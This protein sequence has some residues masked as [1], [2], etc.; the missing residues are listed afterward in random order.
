[1]FWIVSLLLMLL[2]VLF[3]VV[4]V[5][6]FARLQ[7]GSGAG[8]QHHRDSANLM[9]FEER[10][11]EL[12]AEL[13][14]GVLDEEQHQALKAELQRTL[15]ADIKTEAA[16][17]SHSSKEKQVAGKLAPASLL[18]PSRLIPMLT[19]VLMLPLSFYLYGLWGF[20]S[21]LQIAD[22]FERSRDNQGDPEEL[23]DLIFE[24]GA[25]IEADSE[26]GWAWYYLA[27]HLVSLGQINEAARAFERAAAFVE[28]S[29]DRAII[30]GQYAQAAYIAAGQQITADVQEIID[31]AQRLDPAEQSVLQ[32]LGADAFINEN[33]QSAMT[34]WQQ[35][36]GISQRADDREFLQEMIAEAQQR[37]A[38]AGDVSVPVDAGPRLQISLSLDPEL[39]LPPQT[40]V[41]VSAQDLQQA[42]PPLAAKVLT[43]ADLPTVVT[44]SDAD[45]VG[46][47][48]LSSATEVVIVATVSLG[49]SADVQSG[50]LQARSPTLPLSDDEP[51][52]LQLLIADPLP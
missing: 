37:M 1:M 23:R 38:A 8:G 2:A 47:V 50:D 10:L 20:E 12:D 9:I 3:V 30:L 41:F 7:Q 49:G 36:L 26:N 31:Q 14:A 4:P 11:A 45:A 44:L 15:L 43:V 19:I 5:L 52:R 16:A 21:D 35:L 39:D 13:D 6:R 24:L 29:Q 46:P 27:R 32:L 33:Y 17:E 22:V 51:V 40:R 48:N 25:I 18:I 28:N 34:Y 42:G